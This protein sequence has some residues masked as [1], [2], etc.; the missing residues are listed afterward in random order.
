MAARFEAAIL[1]G[2][3][4]DP[5]GRALSN[6]LFSAL[7]QDAAS[8]ESWLIQ[9]DGEL[10]RTPFSALPVNETSAP[11]FI[12]EL[13]DIA[14]APGAWAVGREGSM[15][16]PFTAIADP[17]YNRA[18]PRFQR[19]LPAI[20][21][22]LDS[23]DPQFPRLPATRAEALG[24]ARA[25]SGQTAIVLTGADA[26]RAGLERILAERPA[27]IHLAAHIAV[28]ENSEEPV[29]VLSRGASGATDGLTAREIS[30]LRVP[31]SLVVM[32]GCASARA[33]A[34]RGDGLLGLS[35]AWLSAGARAVIATHWP[36]PDEAGGLLR[37][38]YKH[39]RESGGDTP[40]AL[41]AA[42]VDMIREGG[43]RA[44]TAYWAAYELMERND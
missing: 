43:A 4:H 34:L 26:S 13:H 32:S 20:F 39:L 12:A 41:R 2:R 33:A 15:D 16:G 14:L 24:C 7:P 3:L 10:F 44:N 42:R 37:A 9:P 30:A 23:A 36:V 27:V 11:T 28:D 5:S 1:D 29:I 38:F 22:W 40:K 17:V 8:A 21:Q 35:R 19:L 31:G 18:D 25:F 6:A